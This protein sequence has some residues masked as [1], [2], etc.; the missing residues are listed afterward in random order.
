MYTG[1]FLL[2]LVVG[3]YADT[4][5]QGPTGKENNVF[6]SWESSIA[7]LRTWERT[8]GWAV[9]VICGHWAHYS[10]LINM[11]PNNG[12]FRVL[13]IKFVFLLLNVVKGE[14]SSSHNLVSSYF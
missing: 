14:N 7:L 3:I 13:L 4:M 10:T 5:D 12:K 1:V 9:R 6:V 2:M 11:S 8:V